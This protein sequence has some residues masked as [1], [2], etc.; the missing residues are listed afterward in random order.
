MNPRG[1]R[2]LRCLLAALL[3]GV[4]APLAAELRDA[5]EHGFTA[6]HRIEVTATPAEA[7][8]VMTGHIDQWWD[9]AHSWSGE[10]A[11][12]YLQPAHGGCFCEKL[13]DGGFVEHL[14]IVYLAPGREIRFDGALGP[15]QTMAA[16]GRMNWK[17]SGREDGGSTIGFSYHVYGHPPGG[18]AGIAPAVD[19]VIG[20]QLQRLGARLARP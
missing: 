16:S 3:T 2:L 10:A 17:I 4:A 8:R 13:P 7:W 6:E 14:R 11:N 9:P 5:G 19:G 15:L 12:L 18:L 20:E 1:R